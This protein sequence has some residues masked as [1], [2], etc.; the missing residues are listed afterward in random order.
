VI[1]DNRKSHRAR[2]QDSFTTQHLKEAVEQE[3]LTL[4][5][6]HIQEMLVAESLTTAHLKQ[7][8]QGAERQSVQVKPRS[9]ASGGK[10]PISSAKT[11]SK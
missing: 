3:A 6:G 11:E 1:E 8:L 5:T 2:T 9:T 4:T 7:T 10:R